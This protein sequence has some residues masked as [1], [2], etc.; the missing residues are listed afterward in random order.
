MPP[1]I[2]ILAVTTVLAGCT[3]FDPG[4]D[5]VAIEKLLADKQ[6]RQRLSAI[7][8]RLQ[9]RPGTAIAADLIERLTTHR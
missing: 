4:R 3:T 2:I 9:Q 8:A 1:R 7:S 5:H 6:L